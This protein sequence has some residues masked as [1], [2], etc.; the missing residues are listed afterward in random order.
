MPALVEVS[1]V[2]VEDIADSGIDLKCYGLVY[3]EVVC[4]LEV[5]LEEPGG[6]FSPVFRDI[7]P[8]VLHQHTAGVCP[9]QY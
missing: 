1:L 5:Q 4:D 8:M 2:G 6:D 3:L 9:A 7:S